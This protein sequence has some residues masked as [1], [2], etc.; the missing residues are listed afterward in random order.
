M[1]LED[2]PL[3]SVPG[4]MKTA[5][6][7]EQEHDPFQERECAKSW[8]TSQHRAQNPAVFQSGHGRPAEGLETDPY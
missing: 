5:L 3:V 4:T 2:T 8:D 1:L 6:A 7:T